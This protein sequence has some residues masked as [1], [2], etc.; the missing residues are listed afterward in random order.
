MKKNIS[1]YIS[2]KRTAFRYLHG[3]NILDGDAANG[4]TEVEDTYEEIRK[5]IC[6]ISNKNAKLS[7]MALWSYLGQE[8]WQPCIK[9]HNGRIEFRAHST[10]F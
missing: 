4:S 5:T 3:D 10:R 1:E 8:F 7:N 2:R 6:T 9:N